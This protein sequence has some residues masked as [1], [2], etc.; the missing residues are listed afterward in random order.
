M[1]GIVVSILVI[2]AIASVVVTRREERGRL[3]NEG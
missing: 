3:R 1:L 2:G